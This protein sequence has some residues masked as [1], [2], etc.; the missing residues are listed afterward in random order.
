MRLDLL[1]RPVFLG[2]LCLAA[3]GG[4]GAGCAST[5]DVADV[6]LPTVAPRSAPAV[7]SSSSDPALTS[8]LNDFYG[9]GTTQTPLADPFGIT[10]STIGGIAVRNTLL[11]FGPAEIY[12]P[13]FEGK[14]IHVFTYAPGH[15]HARVECVADTTLSCVP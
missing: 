10:I 15:P 7:E 12:V 5:D 4:L 14:D 1:L 11:G 9:P 2:S 3:W 8:L 13:V 6:A